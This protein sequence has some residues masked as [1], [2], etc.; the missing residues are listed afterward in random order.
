VTTPVVFAFV[1]DPVALGIGA[2]RVNGYGLP[3]SAC[4]PE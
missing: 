3:I 1:T 2:I 4:V